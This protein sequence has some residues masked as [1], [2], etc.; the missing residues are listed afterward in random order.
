MKH[1]FQVYYHG[2]LYSANDENLC[3]R[4]ENLAYIA[5]LNLSLTLNLRAGTDYDYTGKLYNK[6]LA[7]YYRGYSHS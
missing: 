4:S 3:T 2:G 7:H 1:D 5:S 6:G